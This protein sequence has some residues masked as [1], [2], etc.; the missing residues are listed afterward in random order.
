MVPIA[1]HVWQYDARLVNATNFQFKF[2]AN[3]G[4]TTNWGDSAPSQSTLPLAGTAQNGGANISANGTFNGLYRFTFNDQTLAYSLTPLLASPYA[5]MALAGAFNNWN[6][7]LTNMALVTNS[8]WQCDVAFTAPTNIQFK[9]AANGNWTVNW[10]DG[11]Q[12]QTNT[13][14]SGTGQSS[15]ANISAGIITNGTYRFQFNDQTLVYSLQFISA[16]VV[17]NP[18]RLNGVTLSGTGSFH[19]AFTNLSG[20]NFT[21]LSTTNLALSLSNWTALGS[22]PETE[23]GF[24][25]YTDSHAN[26]DQFRFYRVRSP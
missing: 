22:V 8:L 19:F 23:A 1:A 6:A 18:P 21:V 9:F 15:G 5:T 26:A 10:G 3:G 24:Y 17:P 16:V 13:P 11:N 25:E 7:G 12:T 4:W 14:Q 2:A 20:A